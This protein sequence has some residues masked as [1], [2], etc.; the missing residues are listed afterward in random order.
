MGKNIKQRIGAVMAELTSVGKEGFNKHHGYKFTPHDHVSGLLHALFVKHG[1][2]QEVSVLSSKRLEGT[3]TLELEVEV[4]WV[5]VDE[6]AD[7]TRV[8]AYG[9][10]TPISRTKDG[11]AQPDDLG[12]GKA[13]SYAV[14]Y[15]QLKNFTLTGDDT[16]DLETEDGPPRD[17]APIADVE[18]ALNALSAA[19]TKAEFN[20]AAEMATAIADRVTQE[21]QAL[22]G[23]AWTAAK[24]RTAESN[25]T[26][27][28]IEPVSGLDAIEF[29]ALLQDY[30]RALDKEAFGAV[31]KRVSQALGKCSPAQEKA[32]QLADQDAERIVRAASGA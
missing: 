15:A 5:N 11:F 2:V 26:P 8:R 31:R 27:T 22:L 3:G 30:K 1:I 12:V 7:V 24:K 4:A 9:Q 21:Q 25:G 17:A 19:A 28:P 6:P 32:L 29:N 20:A 10:S 23:K 13:L 18:K 14:K 16:P